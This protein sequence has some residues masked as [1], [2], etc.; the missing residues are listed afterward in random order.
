M[1]NQPTTA[2]KK[3]QDIIKAELE[4][5]SKNLWKVYNPTNQDFQVVLNAKVSPEVW[6]IPA[7]DEA[8]VPWYVAEKYFE[9]MSQKIITIKSDRAVIEENE[10][11]RTKGFPGMDLHTEQFRFESRNLK[12]MMSKKEKIIE[13]L[14]KGL[15]QEYGVDKTNQVVIDKRENKENFDP[16][17]DLETSGAG[18]PNIPIKEESPVESP[19]KSDFQEE[20]MDT[21]EEPEEK[22][23]VKKGKNDH[24]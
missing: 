13:I 23:P 12:V 16:G 1:D 14:N 22:T 2:G 24:R 11:R 15:Y 5:V 10:K 4:R 8:I 17:L 21:E 9:E 3:S 18:M 6:T 20:E 19:V 7:K